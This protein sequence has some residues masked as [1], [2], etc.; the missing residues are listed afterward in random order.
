MYEIFMHVR[1]QKVIHNCNSMSITS[2]FLRS[3][4]KTEWVAWFTSES[5]FHYEN[6]SKEKKTEKRETKDLK[7]SGKLASKILFKKLLS[8][9]Y[10]TLNLHA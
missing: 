1:V 8:F 5:L 9:Y 3:L 10:F 4:E 7:F 6:R 2:E